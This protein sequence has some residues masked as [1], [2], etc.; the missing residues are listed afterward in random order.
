MIELQTCRRG[1]QVCL[2]VIDTGVGIPR[3]VQE[4][5]FQVFFSTRDSGTGL[6]LPTV[7]KI[8]E[9]ARRNDSLRQRA[10][11]GDAVYAFLPL[12]PRVATA[13]GGRSRRG[14][15]GERE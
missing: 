12:R 7:R 3:A 13:R 6:G 9:R 15:G 14:G 8:V 11:P 2:D 4:K 5:L 1:D 10:G